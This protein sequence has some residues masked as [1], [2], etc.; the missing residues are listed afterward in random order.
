[1]RLHG[2]NLGVACL[3]DCLV[4]YVSCEVACSTGFRSDASFET[5]D[6]G[7]T[8]RTGEFQAPDPSAKP[9]LD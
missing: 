2:A 8:V 9:I 7:W 1:M 3:A 5:V 4:D 6:A